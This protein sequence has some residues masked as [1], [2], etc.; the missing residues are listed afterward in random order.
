[1]RIIKLALISLAL[2]ACQPREDAAGGQ[3]DVAAT[4]V[5]TGDVPEPGQVLHLRDVRGHADDVRL[6]VQPQE[7]VSGSH[8][9]QHS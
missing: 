4:V 2:C 1:M 9:A 3:L 5:L 8:S 6:E 7:L